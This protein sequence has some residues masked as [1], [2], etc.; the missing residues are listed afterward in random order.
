MEQ[1][2]SKLERNIS[3]DRISEQSTTLTTNTSRTRETMTRERNDDTT[4]T[5]RSTERKIE[6]LNNEIKDIEDKNLRETEKSDKKIEDN[7][8]EIKNLK[9]EIEQFEA[10]ITELEN[11]YKSDKETF[12]KS[13]KDED[14]NFQS[15]EKEYT[16]NME[17][18]KEEAFNNWYKARTKERFRHLSGVHSEYVVKKP[19][20]SFKELNAEFS[21]MIQAIQEPDDQLLYKLTLTPFHNFMKD[22]KIPLGINLNCLITMLEN[23][24]YPGCIIEMTKI[25]EEMVSDDAYLAIDFEKYGLKD[26]GPSKPKNSPLTTPP[27]LIRLAHIKLKKKIRRR[28]H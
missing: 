20:K 22:L 16:N 23:Q 5:D 21:Q 12:S 2:I 1:N 26:E 9:L 7:K 6:K 25:M 11:K 28:K 3:R 8:E 14:K 27:F 4:M 10:E 13:Q 19:T 17:K 18:A 24:V 15:L